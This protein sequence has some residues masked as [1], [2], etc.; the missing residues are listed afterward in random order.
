MRLERIKGEPSSATEGPLRKFTLDLARY[1]NRFGFRIAGGSDSKLGGVFVTHLA[2]VGAASACPGFRMGMRLLEVNGR[3][4]LLTSQIDNT[5]ILKLGGSVVHIVAQVLNDD[6]WHVMYQTTEF[7]KKMLPL[8]L[9]NGQSTAGRVY[10]VQLVRTP[11]T[12]GGIGVTLIGGCETNY[13]ATF[14]ETIRPGTPAARDGTLQPGDR[15]LA[16]NG[17]GCLARTRA[18]VKL[19]LNNDKLFSIRLL[20]MHL[21]SEQWKK[22][23]AETHK[24]ERIFNKRRL[25]QLR[26]LRLPRSQLSGSVPTSGQ[27]Y[28]I[29]LHRPKGEPLGFRIEGGS[30]TRMGACFVKT[31]LPGGLAEKEG[32]LHVGDRLLEVSGSSLIELN[33]EAGAKALQQTGQDVE[34]VVQRLGDSRWCAL[35]A[36]L[37]LGE[38]RR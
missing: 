3:S 35:L 6:D 7:A 13:G 31:I 25:R 22:I 21:G 34:L 23:E 38:V 37:T 29:A 12:A 33:Q 24:E 17:I 27:L 5:H 15:I 28:V 26:A 4:V 18:D 11:D 16:I 30:D 20:V 32:S 8:P 9:L 36:S 10:E 2:P 19:L 14:I 1:K